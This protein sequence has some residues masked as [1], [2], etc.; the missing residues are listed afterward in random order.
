[1]LTLTHSRKDPGFLMQGIDSACFSPHH[2]LPLK[3]GINCIGKNSHFFPFVPWLHSSISLVTL[4]GGV[5][6]IL[7]QDSER[8]S[9]LMLTNKDP[10]R[11]STQSRASF[12]SWEHQ[13]HRDFVAWI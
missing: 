12:A 4:M 6:F 3:N 11:G 1:M 2:L 9:P 7:A 10:V 13:W 8:M 5:P